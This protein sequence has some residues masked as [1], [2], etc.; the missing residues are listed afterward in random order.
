[1]VYRVQGLGFIGCR[2]WKNKSTTAVGRTVIT[3][4]MVEE[5]AEPR[6]GFRI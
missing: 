5:P 1:M 2:G 4:V 3:V 6:L